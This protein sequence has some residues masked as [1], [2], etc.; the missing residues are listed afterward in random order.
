MDYQVTIQMSQDTINYLAAKKYILY[1]FKGVVSSEGDAKPSIWFSLNPDT[2]EFGTATNIKWESPLYIGK[3]S[4]GESSGSPIISSKSPWPSVPGQPVALAKAYTYE[5]TEDKGW[6]LEPEKGPKGAFEIRNHVSPG[7]SNYYVAST[8]VTT[9]TESPIIV[10]DVPPG[11]AATFTPIETVAFIFAQ[12]KYDAGTLIVQTFSS[13][14]LVAFAGAANRAT[15]AYDHKGDGWQSVDVPSPAQFSTF[16]SGTPLY[17]AM[18]GASQQALAVAIDQ[19]EA[20]LLS[21]RQVLTVLELHSSL[22]EV[23]AVNSNS[24][25]TTNSLPYRVSFLRAGAIQET[26]EPGEAKPL[27]ISFDSLMVVNPPA[28]PV[29]RKQNP[30]RDVNV[31]AGNVAFLSAGAAGTGT[32][33]YSYA[34]PGDQETVVLFT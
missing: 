32:I 29:V 9:G 18:T 21:H 33:K 4:V 26:L 5:L 19:L 25:P 30:L 20:L 7:T 8:L 12:A 23:K 2:P 3:C 27:T 31:P 28:P 34:M 16:W 15:I 14:S 22:A 17:K 1:G 24:I 6:K 11:G 13:G 10:V